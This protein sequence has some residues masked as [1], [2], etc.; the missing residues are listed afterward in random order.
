M[1]RR[2]A[3]RRNILENIYYR[4]EI[5]LKLIYL[6]SKQNNMEP[7]EQ[8]SFFTI[9]NSGK[10]SDIKGKLFLK[11]CLDI[12]S[13]EVSITTLDRGS[14]TPF[15]HRHRQNEE[16]YIILAGQGLMELEDDTYP[17][18][19][20]SMVRVAPS[21]ARGLVNT[22]NEPLRFICVQAKEHSL[23]GYTLGDGW[24]VDRKNE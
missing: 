5:G 11:E 10:L 24:K 23:E 17:I 9:V 3:R 14:K 7:L 8:N 13:M 4:G 16:L 1:Y 6:F 12:T 18:E 15:L 22:G 20:G 21:I 19:E 2:M